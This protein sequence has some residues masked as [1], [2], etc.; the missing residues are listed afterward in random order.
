MARHTAQRIMTIVPLLTHES[1]YVGIDV[2]KHTHV[3]GFVSNTLLQR[4]KHFEGC[5]SLKFA[6]SRE[7]FRSLIDRISEYVGP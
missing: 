6:Q 3:A 7:G 2:G 1:V 5:P 4:H